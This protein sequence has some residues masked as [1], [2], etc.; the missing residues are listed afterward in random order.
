[1]EFT[2]KRALIV[3]LLSAAFA[4]ASAAPITI[5]TSFPKEITDTYKKAFEQKYPDIK[6]EVLNKNTTA[7]LAFIKEAS[8]GQRADIFWASA[9]DAFEVLSREKLLS[10]AGDIKNS[11]AP[12]KIGNYPMNDPDGLY[13][14]QALSG[15]GLMWNTRYLKA[16]KLPA[17]AE[18]SDLTKGIYFGHVAV[19]APSRSGTTHLTVETMLQGEGW[20][21]GWM[22]LIEI[23]GNCKAITERSFGVPDGV[24]SGQFGIGMVIDFFGLAGKYS[25]FPVE[26]AYPTVTSVVPASIGLINGAKNPTDASKFMAFSLS[27]EG[28][29]LLLDPKISR[30]PIVSYDKLQGKVPAGYPNIFDVAKKSKVQFNSDLAQVRYHV[31]TSMFDQTITFRHKELQATTKAIHEAEQKLAAKPNPQA[32]ELIKQA[33]ELAYSPVVDEALLKKPAFLDLFSKSVSKK[34][35][36]E[37]AD[38]QLANLEDQWNSKAKAN[39]AKALELAQQASAAIK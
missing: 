33:R 34:G 4:N 30:M 7:S 28:Q 19:S 8:A 11:A 26:F 35:M 5:I 1:M 31:V 39:Y 22:Q 18:W 15:Y 20:D 25:G 29:A 13:Y 6:V 12:E 23:A 21:K 37:F 32:A 36:G 24:N 14:G 10:K 17:P 3:S 9:P 38:K 16:N 27:N 2:F